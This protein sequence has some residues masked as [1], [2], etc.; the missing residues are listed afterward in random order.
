VDAIIQSASNKL[1]VGSEITLLVPGGALI[2]SYGRVITSPRKREKSGLQPG[3][4]YVSF[5]NYFPETD[6][7]GFR[8]TWEIKNGRIQP[9]NAEDVQ[10]E[11]EGRS[12]FAGMP[13]ADFLDMVKGQLSSCN[14]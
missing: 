2:L 3:R 1:E 6:S 14:N 7:Y 9:V 8:Q 12:R 10:A 11:K 5:A 13:V 4:T